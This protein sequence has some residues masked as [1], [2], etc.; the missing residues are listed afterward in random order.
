MKIDTEKEK[1]LDKQSPS[2]IN[3]SRVVGYYGGQ[4]DGPLFIALSGVHGNEKAGVQ[5]LTKV[6]NKL[7][8]NA[9]K[10]KGMFIAVTGNL[11]A[12]K[13]DKR[14][15]D[16][17]LNR[18][19]YPRKVNR[20]QQ[21]PRKNLLISEDVQQK[22]LLILFNYLKRFYYKSL[23]NRFKKQVV[24]IDLHT[25][26]GKGGAYSI[27]THLGQ[28]KEFA[29]KLKVPV[30]IG[31]ENVLRGTTMHYFND[32][33]MVSYSFE[34][35]QHY[36]PKSI[37]VTEAAVWLSLV[38]VGCLKKTDVPEYEKYEK[39]LDD[40]GRNLPK[41]V[42]F[43]Y[44]HAITEDDEFTMRAGF[45]NFQPIAKGELLAEDKYGPIYSPIEG[46][47]LM[48]LYQKQGVDGFF[49]V[50]EAEEED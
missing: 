1:V 34:A 16:V 11:S 30:I 18:Q 13:M 37:D 25:F 31:L 35:G 50:K 49:I 41:R 7:E 22:E 2:P 23:R 33:E 19:W 9:S 45:R 17:D 5:A 32:L 8:A 15:I 46:L 40:I 12:F 24:M 43:C 36:D 14:Y 48:P 21:T 29:S 27:A 38:S 47:M 44:R 10:L 26:S 3:D 28:S 42:E 4:Q 6:F 39:I 20:I